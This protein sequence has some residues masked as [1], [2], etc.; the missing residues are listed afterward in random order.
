M[1]SRFKQPLLALALGASLLMP[2]LANSEDIDIFMGTS[3]G[4]S[5]NA[6]V[7]FVLDN[8]SNWSRMSEKWVD[9]NGLAY[10]QGQAEVRAIITALDTVGEDIN[11]G[12]MGYGTGSGNGADGGFLRFAV[13]EMI[14]A[15]KTALQNILRAID[16]RIGNSLEKVNSGPPL[17]DLFHDVY[18][19][20]SAGTPTNASR[21]HPDVTDVDAYTSNTFARFSSP[22]NTTNTCARTIVIFIGNPD[23]SGPTVDKIN[24]SPG[25]NNITS[26]TTLTTAA[27]GTTPVVQLNLPTFINQAVTTTDTVGTTSACY[28]S[29]EAAAAGI[30][31]FPNCSI[32]SQGCSVAEAAAPSEVSCPANSNTYTVQ[33]NV[34]IPANDGNSATVVG[35]IVTTGPTTGYYTSH[36]D[37]PSTDRGTMTCPT[38]T[39]TQTHACTTTVTSNKEDSTVPYTRLGTTIDCYSAIGTGGNHKWADGATPTETGT[40]AACPANA[41]CTYSG[42]LQEQSDSSCGG[43]RKKINITQTITPRSRYTVSRSV[44]TT[45][46][47]SGVA[48]P[49]RIDSERLGMTS[50]CYATR[51][52]STSDFAASCTGTNVSCSIELPTSSSKATCS[53]GTSAY[54]IIGTDIITT[55]V[56]T[57]TSSRDT[58]TYNADEWARFLF[59]HGVP[60]PGSAT[61]ERQSVITN[62]IDVYKNTANAPYTSLYLSMANAG[63]G[64]YFL[65]QSEQDIVDAINTILV[66]LQAT[67]SAFAATSLPVNATNRSQNENQVFIGMFR[68]DSGSKPRWVGNLKRYQLVIRGSSV[69][70]AGADPTVL[71]LDNGTGFFTDCAKSW[72]TNDTVDYWAF[73]TPAVNFAT[74]CLT[75]G[76]QLYPYSDAPDGPQVEKGG[77]AQILR[78]GNTAGAAGSVRTLNRNMLTF[79][80]T[81]LVPFTAA[82]S[83]LD[84]D[85]VQFIRGA[86]INE[87]KP[88]TASPPLAPAARTRPS[89]HGDVIHSRPLPLNYGGGNVTVFYGANDG[90][91]RAVDA[92]SGVEK[93]SFVPP[94]FFPNLARLKSN[95]PRV[96]Y[97][98]ITSANTPPVPLR[99]NYFYDGSIG[100]YQNR[101]SSKVWIYPTM[102]RGGRMLYALDVTDPA[103]PSYLWKQGCSR[104]DGGCTEGMSGI[105]QT[106]STPTVAFTKGYTTVGTVSV[107]AVAKPI[108][109]MGGGYDTCE[110]DNLAVPTTPCT[111]G[112]KVYIFDAQDGTILATL[113]TEKSVAGDVTVIDIDNDNLI[114]YAYAADVGGALYRISFINGPVTK[115]ALTKNT[116]SIDKVAY[117]K[118]PVLATGSEGYRKFLAA[119]A[120]FYSQSMIYVAIGSG[121]REHPLKTDYAYTTPVENRFYVFKDNLTLLSTALVT[122]VPKNLDLLENYTDKTVCNADDNIYPTS[123]LNGWYIRL[124]RGTG[125]QTV[126]S[127]LIA[128]GLVAFS[129]NRPL[130]D[131]A[132]CNTKLGEAAGYLV[133]LFSASGAIGVDGSCGGARSSLFAGG[134]LPPNPVLATGVQIGTGDTAKSVTVMFG[135]VSKDGTVSGAL[136]PERTRPTVRPNRKK[137]YSYTK[138]D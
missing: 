85:L 13:K 27:G 58:A 76:V 15:N 93:W 24:V 19:Y 17:G 99:K 136:S 57:F 127:A 9:R 113:N 116:W 83:L 106:W 101:D 131:G 60:V 47:S 54:R 79:D 53:A 111:K 21:A 46:T 124:N 71:A 4:R 45:T 97:P 6:N 37:V 42:V 41:S 80:G 122:L 95:S 103:S 23:N 1:I 20:L 28:A 115:V 92:E 68:P 89:I 117:T 26:L 59:N 25:P 36:A 33:R 34:R 49:E 137:V 14:P 69:E 121:D 82:S 30:S 134:G 132:S 123:P 118:R 10:T 55:N 7:L 86:D 22:L 91:L 16:A 48:T 75:T 87:E 61:N 70:L 38:N 56:P 130:E 119:P 108:V 104:S 18:N 43:N 125:E 88:S 78:Q 44:T 74:R 129:T 107:P 90:A 126:T 96:F 62:T 135:A 81:D 40:L 32:Y 72:W 35:P 11:V 66:E 114:D 63:G 112:N 52:T 138:S 128:G 110:D 102:R 133:N 94:E 84:E 64:K 31:A 8:T 39:A 73:G 67:N 100:V 105:G 98:G 65:A 2:S 29:R 109:I 12:I 77:A 50:E 120:V 51:P 3:S 5:G